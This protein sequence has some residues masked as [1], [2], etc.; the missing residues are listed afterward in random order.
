MAGTLIIGMPG[1]KGIGGTASSSIAL[2]SVDLQSTLK[3]SSSGFG[4]K[5][6]S[7]LMWTTFDIVSSSSDEAFRH[8]L[9]KLDRLSDFANRYGA[10]YT[11]SDPVYIYWGA[12]GELPV[13]QTLVHDI[14]YELVPDSVLTAMLGKDS[15]KL[16]L[17]VQH[18]PFWSDGTVSSLYSGT[19]PDLG[20]TYA[21]GLTDTSYPSRIQ[22]FNMTTLSGLVP[23]LEKA[24]IGIKDTRNG[25][26]GL[27]PKW[28]AEYG[29]NA[30]DASD[31][32]GTT[33]SNGT[34]VVVSFATGTAMAK[35]FSIKLSDITAGAYD[36]N[37]GKYLV[38][39]R[40]KVSGTATII[41]TELKHGWLGRAGLESSVGVS[42]LDQTTDASLVNYNL[43]P[44]GVVDVPPTGDRSG[45]AS[46]G[47]IQSYGLALYAER[48]SAAGSLFC[49][50]FILVPTDHLM[51]VGSAY[52]YSDGG[53]SLRA[54][55]G[56]DDTPYAINYSI[57]S[58]YGNTE[59]S[60]EN[61][62]VPIGGG[63]LVIAAQ[64]GTEHVINGTITFGMDIVK[65]YR[66]YRGT[67]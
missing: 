26:L 10:D 39:G 27:V 41:A 65:R 46:N 31:V 6:D 47:P 56:D 36:D 50:C 24:W 22:Y 19:I 11:L 45:I 8:E 5:T 57:S 20:G 61:W 25:V 13:R 33:A 53:A 55:A 64:G 42:F 32:A 29:T 37:I 30:T 7:D 59:Y 9:F 28:E 62:N 66:S 14:V 63:M 43:I 4:Y 18:D 48:L 23:T 52:M 38:L 58:Y 49:D 3:V 40:M 17:A 16:R 2:G 15:A 44:L 12:D 54:Y 51:T 60:F 34:A 1:T 67:S 21:L 35:R